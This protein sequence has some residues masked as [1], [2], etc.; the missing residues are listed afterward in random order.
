MNMQSRKFF[1][2]ILAL[3][4]TPACLIT[5]QLNIPPLESV[6]GEHV[7]IAI[8]DRAIAGYYWGIFGYCTHFNDRSACMTDTKGAMMEGFFYIGKL[9]GSYN[10]ARSKTYYRQKSVDDC[11]ESIFNYGH[12]FTYGR[13]HREASCNGSVC[14]P[15]RSAIVEA[16]Q[17]LPRFVI[18]TCQLLPT[19]KVLSLSPLNL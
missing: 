2:F 13:L 11:L 18:P 19:G 4:L 1:F 17:L 16:G 14:H 3:G 15:D 7:R 8:E 6:P 5:D 10:P 9:S 12:L